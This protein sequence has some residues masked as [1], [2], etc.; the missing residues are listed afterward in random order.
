MDAAIST[1]EAE[2]LTLLGEHLT[3][4]EIAARLFLSVRTVESHVASLRRKLGITGHRDLV[5]FATS[6]R[7]ATSPDRLRALGAARSL[8]TFVGRDH[9]RREL[10]AAVRANRLVSL[11]GPG[12]AGKTRLAEA[13][14]DDL[15][16]SFEDR[17]WHVDLVPVS[18]DAALAS[19]I[20]SACGMADMP[21]RIAEDAM[22]RAFG[23]DTCLLVLDNCEHVVNAVAVLVESLSAQCPGMHVLVTTRV[24]L[25]V[26]FEHVFPL[27]GLAGAG[28]ALALFVERA[29][30]A[31]WDLPDDAQRARM[32]AVCSAVDR[33]PLAIE[34]AA[35]RLPALGLDGVERGLADQPALLVGGARAQ[36]RQRSMNDTLSWS[37]RLLGPLEQRILCRT[38]VFAAAFSA[39]TAREVVAFGSLTMADVPTALGTLVDHSLLVPVAGTQDRRWRLL[40]PVRQFALTQM[41]VPDAAAYDSHCDWVRT[42]V[43]HLLTTSAGGGHRWLADFDDVADEMRAA[44]AWLISLRPERDEAP[45]LAHDLAMLLFRAGHLREA[46]RRFEQ[47][48]ELAGQPRIAAQRLVEASDVARCRVLGEEAF[49]LDLAAVEQC[50][51]GDDRELLALALARGAETVFRFEGMFA[52]TVPMDQGTGLL[53]EM[54]SAAGDAAV[55]TAA[56]VVSLNRANPANPYSAREAERAVRLAERLGDRVRQSAAMDVLTGTYLM[57]G[58]LADAADCARRRVHLLSGQPIEPGVGLELKDALHMAVLCCVGAGDLSGAVDY[59]FAHRNLGFLREQGDLGIES[60]L[61]PDALSGNW[62]RV[63]DAGQLFKED[64]IAA[65][66][67]SAA[68]RAIGP[69]A[70]AMVHGALGHDD[71]RSEWLD[72]VA[73]LMGIPAARINTESGFGAV[74]EG[75]MLLHRDDAGAAARVLSATVAPGWYAQL[76]SQWRACLVAEAVVLAG[77]PDAASY[78]ERARSIMDRNGLAGLIVDRAERLLRGDLYEMDDVAHRFTASGVPYQAERTLHLAGRENPVTPP[79][80]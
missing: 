4:A 21:G 40:E 5:R 1:R 15:S 7:D 64:W 11:V 54:A 63:L 62:S 3:H 43:A 39:N 78:V 35:V 26:P 75:M 53:N 80:T 48:A 49:R 47:S 33:L 56:H 68:G 28:E 44:L 66:R 38:A 10:A 51:L 29:M 71:Q 32:D 41:Q 25:V 20:A 74:F 52:E 36:A 42:R 31:G 23:P 37:Y 18:D 72:I 27:A 19:A 2:V 59:G 61:T 12:G 57:S 69:C 45:E 9:E 67:P 55:Y 14:V 13:V 46:Q 8:T 16:P 76:L 22:V 79:H 73:E 65:G 58:R 34:L 17:V 50:R 6:R 70:V 60:T 30:A 24:R 77:Y